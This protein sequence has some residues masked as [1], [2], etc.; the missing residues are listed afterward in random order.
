MYIYYYFYF[1]W[2]LTLDLAANSWN[3]FLYGSTIQCLLCWQP[4]NELSTLLAYKCLYVHFGFAFFLSFFFFS[5]WYFHKELFFN[6]L[7]KLS[8][9]IIC[10]SFCFP[11]C[12]FNTKTFLPKSFMNSS[13]FWKKISI[14][15]TT[16][17]KLSN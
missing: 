6:Y 1:I 8:F 7:I 16:Q 13:I 11:K 2:F 17:K 15:I 4:S 12:N 14:N 10:P 9:F 3:L 5:K